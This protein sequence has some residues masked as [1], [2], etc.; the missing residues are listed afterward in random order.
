MPSA[1]ADR[2]TAHAQVVSSDRRQEKGCQR[3]AEKNQQRVEQTAKHASSSCPGN[4]YAEQEMCLSSGETRIDH[5]KR[6][7]KGWNPPPRRDGM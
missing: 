5:S 6:Q 4:L 7:S 2:L 3:G 1:G